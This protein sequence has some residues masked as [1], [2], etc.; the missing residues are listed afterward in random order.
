[1]KKHKEAVV[2]FLIGVDSKIIVSEINVSDLRI[3][4]INLKIHRFNL[5]V[6]DV[7]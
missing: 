1:M 3:I 2:G 6:P 5:L 7:H 4:A